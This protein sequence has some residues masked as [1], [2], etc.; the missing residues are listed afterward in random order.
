MALVVFVLF[1]LM[2]RPKGGMNGSVQA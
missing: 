1:A 2:F